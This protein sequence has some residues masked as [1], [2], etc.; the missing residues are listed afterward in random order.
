MQIVDSAKDR[1]FGCEKGWLTFQREVVNLYLASGETG[2]NC[3]P[4][5]NSG[6]QTAATK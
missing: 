5:A 2:V 1:L 3:L 4:L 6:Q